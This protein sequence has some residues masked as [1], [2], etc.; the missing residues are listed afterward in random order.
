LTASNIPQSQLLEAKTAI[1]SAGGNGW[2]ALSAGTGFAALFLLFLPGGR[3]RYRAALGLG[4]VCILSF[5]LGCGGGYGGGGGGLT[6]TVTKLTVPSAKVASGTA[7][8]F[9]V[10]VTG[11]TPGGQVVLF[12]NGTMIG[13][14]ATVAG[15]T[16]APTAPALAVGTHVITAHYQGDAYTM[17]SASGAINMTVTGT[18]SVA[19]TTSPVA[20]PV[21]P[22]LSVTIN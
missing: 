1:P 4:L 10:T 3:N 12:D 9:S 21:A 5:T 13:T 14:A 7:F 17:A 16:A 20:A 2:W 22:A 15:G 19:I 11:G 18:T 8:T 6:P